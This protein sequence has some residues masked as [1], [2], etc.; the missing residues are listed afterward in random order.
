MSDLSL[1]E[2]CVDISDPADNLDFDPAFLQKQGKPPQRFAVGGSADVK[3]FT[4]N[5]AKS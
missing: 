4:Q 2:H 3:S 5:S 1:S